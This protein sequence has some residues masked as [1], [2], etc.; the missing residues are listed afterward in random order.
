MIHYPHGMHPLI[1]T[2]LIY[3]TSLSDRGAHYKQP[4]TEFSS[5][6]Q[7]RRYYVATK[8]RTPSLESIQSP[9]TS[10]SIA[11]SSPPTVQRHASQQASTTHQSTPTT[12]Q[13]TTRPPYPMVPSSEGSLELN[14]WTLE[15]INGTP[16]RECDYSTVQ[17]R[18]THPICKDPEYASSLARP[19]RRYSLVDGMKSRRRVWK[20]NI[21]S[22]R[23]TDGA[24]NR[25]TPEDPT[26]CHYWP[27]MHPLVE[28]R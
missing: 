25:V 12:M 10:T 7:R 2:D 8:F 5:E 24:N 19:M 6:T 11:S 13:R 20:P 23:T 9:G 27:M 17:S 3:C 22:S 16:I 1:S 18:A 21:P 15:I 26:R 4:L 28:C 14:P